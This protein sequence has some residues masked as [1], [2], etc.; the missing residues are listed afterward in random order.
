MDMG[1]AMTRPAFAEIFDLSMPLPAIA[2]IDPS[3]DEIVLAEEEP[4]SEVEKFITRRRK[5][6][7][8][9]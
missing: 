4:P 3:T 6:R 1:I 2:T 8:S 7:S 5:R 9:G